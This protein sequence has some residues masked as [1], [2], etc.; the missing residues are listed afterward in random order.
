MTRHLRV[1]HLPAGIRGHGFHLLGPTGARGVREGIDLW[2]L[3][4]DHYNFSFCAAMA[5]SRV[6]GFWLDGNG[7]PVMAAMNCA[8][9]SLTR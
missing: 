2:K 7:R 8:A 9:R 1:D 4:A 6:L 5:A 3:T